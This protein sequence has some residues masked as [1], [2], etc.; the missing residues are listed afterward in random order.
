MICRIRDEWKIAGSNLYII[1][2]VLVVFLLFLAV[3]AGELLD[4]GSIGFEVIF[5]F[6]AA[7][8]VGEWGKTKSDDNY[9]VIAA[10]S[11]SVFN[12]LAIRY[13]AVMGIVSVFAVA[14]MAAV[15]L[16]RNE[17]T[18]M[19][20]LLTHFPTSFLLS[21]LSMS[22]GFHFEKE[23]IGAMTCGVIWL[24]FLMMRGLLQ[25]PIVQYFYLFIRFADI[26]SN[27]WIMNK[28]ILF[29]I[30]AAIWYEVYRACKRRY[31]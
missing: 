13:I 15:C 29:I 28:G 3:F 5:P 22:I 30:S 19:E 21:S 20:L 25:F 7:I 27:I 11:S 26:Q 12:W 31:S 2:G 24:V 17:V 6:Y 16:L 10:Q 9:D 8:A 18:Y 4:V 23:H 14:G 1:S